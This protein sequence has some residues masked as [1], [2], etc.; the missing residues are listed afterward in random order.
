L[1]FLAQNAPETAWRP[2]SALTRW[3]SLS[4]PTHTLAAVKRLDI[5]G[6]ERKGEENGSR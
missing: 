5:L 2:G 3:E 4:D 1:L 6:G